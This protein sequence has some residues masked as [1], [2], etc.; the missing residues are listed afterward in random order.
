MGR[1]DGRR[2]TTA[3][4]VRDLVPGY[5]RL[6]AYWDGG[7]VGTD[8]SR[9]GELVIGRDSDADL[10]VP[11]PSVSRHHARVRFSPELS[12]EDLGTVNGTR[13]G[14]RL[15]AK[16]ERAPVLPGAI[17]EV[18]DSLLVVQQPE[19][20]SEPSTAA[21]ANMS[22]VRELIE[23]I[24]P[25][26]IPVT[27]VGETGVGKEVLAQKLH[28]G[29]AR[30]D[31]PFIRISCVAL[32]EERVESE[33]C[34]AASNGSNGARS[35]LLEAAQGG[36]LFFDDVAE[37]PRPSQD[38]LLRVLESQQ[39]PRAGAFASRERDV[40][41]VAATQRDLDVMVT[42]GQFRADLFHR[43]CGVV[44]RVPPLR[45]RHDEIVDLARD[46]AGRVSR[47]L[48]RETPELGP[49]FVHALQRHAWP[50]NL[51]ELEH[52]VECAVL[53]AHGQPLEG[54]HLPRS[55]LSGSSPPA[56][57]PAQTLS[58]ELGAVERERI[59]V[60]LEKCAG[61]QSRAARLLGMPR[62]TLI[63]RITEYGL[64]RPRLQHKQRTR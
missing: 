50:G 37:L 47:T 39:C 26:N 14:G 15:L 17:V 23:R 4:F 42:Q 62:R 25:G 56:A 5:V 27:F 64:P 11:H 22:R 49:S 3:R 61:N 29:S 13:V 40:R 16:G 58:S 10:C 8:A 34:G 35:G 41:F 9:A 52:A 38:E 36:T 45:E 21:S 60:A 57:L 43:I 53:L 48:G 51:R 6:V 32:T 19:S 20:V 63:D 55:V 18:G 24:A 7:S 31:G 59:A 33:L 30:R 2:S 46:F 44:V 54:T 1:E 28:A 12:I